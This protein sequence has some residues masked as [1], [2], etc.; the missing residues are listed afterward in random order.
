M[1]SLNGGKGYYDDTI[2]AYHDGFDYG[3]GFGY[4]YN[5]GSYGYDDGFYGRELISGRTRYGR[6]GYDSKDRK[7]DW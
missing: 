6:D 2:Y 5:G 7:N 3:Q 4:G 1:N